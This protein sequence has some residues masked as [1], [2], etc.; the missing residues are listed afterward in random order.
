MTPEEYIKLALRTN[1]DLGHKGNI[2]HGAMLC[3]TESAEILSELKKELAYDK[4]LDTT[5]VIEEMG[6]VT[7]G[8]ALLASELGVSFSQVF[9]ANIKKL[10][11][12]YPD[13]RFSADHANN[14]DTEAEDL[15]VRGAIK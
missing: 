9:E 11:A 10:E 4:K 6:D 3:C 13:L 15:A 12:R 14:R 2:L 8:L 7:W 1:K 5:K